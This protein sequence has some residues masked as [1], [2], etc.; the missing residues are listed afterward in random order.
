MSFTLAGRTFQSGESGLA[1]IAVT[2]M[3][4]G[5]ALEVMAHVLVGQRDGPVVGLVSTHHGDEMFT[6]EVVRRV[7]QRL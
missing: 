4:S 5:L 3:A 7:K 6:I 2:T 1:R